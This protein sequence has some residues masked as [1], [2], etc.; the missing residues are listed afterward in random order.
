MKK[1][2]S[3]SSILTCLLSLGLLSLNTGCK[4]S[5]FDLSNID[6]TIGIGGDELVLPTSDTENIMLD[7]VLE[8][9]NSDL[10]SILDNGD[11]VFRKEGAPTDPSHPNIEKTYV[12]QTDLKDNFPVYITLPQSVA[13]TARKGSR[14]MKVN[15]VSFSGKVA[16]FDYSGETPYEIK[17]VKAAGVVSNVEIRVNPS[18]NLK[19]TIP[20]FNEL[21]IVLPAF[22]KLD[23]T[24]CSAGK[25]NYTYD[26]STGKITLKNVNTS[27]PIFIKGIIRTLDFQAK[28][29]D[30]NYLKFKAG[31]SE[32][33]GAVI[34]KGTIYT[35]GTFDEINTGT[36]T[37]DMS[38]SV[39][40][41]MGRIEIDSAEGR[42]DP[43]ID[44]KDLGNVVINNVPDF[45]TDGDVKIN[46]HNPMVDLHV[47]S[48]I[49]VAGFVSG[50]IIAKDE[51]NNVIKT[52]SVPEMR[53]K[54]NA[55]T[56]ICIC[57]NKDGIDGSGYDDVV[58]VPNLSELM[59]TIPHT[60][61]FEAKARADASTFSNIQFGHEYTISPSYSVSAPLAFD[62]GA[63]IVYRD[64]IDG[65]HDDID[66]YDLA[67][68]TYI[69]LTT[70][71][72]NKIPAYLTVSANAI[73]ADGN[74]IPQSDIKVEVSNQVKASADGETAETTPVTI[75]LKELKKG[76]IKKV[77]GLTFRVEASSD[78]GNNANCIVGKT[79]NAK[80]HTLTARNIKVKLVGRIIADLN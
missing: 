46:L 49:N 78:D 19:A 17:E 1:D 29:T 32:E 16:Q 24:S 21:S 38:L 42:F 57:K 77:D 3:K 35:S 70:D 2:I 34:L 30:D 48:D 56:H 37:S 40:M 41:A 20:S 58:V 60:L 59:Y 18:V 12:N 75:T 8:L 53:I 47:A 64:T 10:V 68:G 80:K 6:S 33:K 54:P 27:M 13:R 76:T 74:E 67:E 31:V 4:D 50:F 62:E 36:N 7:D 5:D 66:D 43:T 28:A 55:T 65:W 26:I 51:S 52:V 73:D 69:E 25:D 44:L 9:N 23:V 39:A 71:V 63:R 79:I 14:H 72:V 22:M 45:L 11:Y 15:A 61:N